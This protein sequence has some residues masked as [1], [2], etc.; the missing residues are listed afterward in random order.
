M[1][2]KPKNRVK[3]QIEDWIDEEH[4]NKIEDWAANGLTVE[5]IAKNIGISTASLYNWREQE[6]AIL[7]AIKRGRDTCVD[8]VEN[9]LF[10]SAINGNVTAQIFVLKNKRPDSYKDKREDKVEVTP[11]EITLTIN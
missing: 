3:P 6:P 7:E 2:K 9:A 8:L 10:K 1:V 4:L 5:Q 11:N